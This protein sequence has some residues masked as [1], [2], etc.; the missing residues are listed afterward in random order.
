MSLRSWISN[1]DL[2]LSHKPLLLVFWGI[3]TF[4]VAIGAFALIFSYSALPPQVPL[5]FTAEKGLTGKLLL[6]VVPAL[7]IFFLIVNAAVSEFLL[8]KREDAAA[9]FPAFLS[10]LVSALLTGSL[11]RILRI[12]PIPKSPL[13]ELLYPLLLPFGGAVF[14]G[15]FITLGTLFL[16][17]RLRLFDRPHGPYPEVRSIPRLGALPLFLAFGIVALLFLP[18]DPALKGLLLGAGI[19][20]LIQTV[21]DLHSLPFWVQGLGHLIAAGAVIWGGIRVTYIGNPL[22]PYLAPRY[23][24]FSAVPYLSELV[25][26]VWIF[27]LINVVDWLDGLD[28]LAAGIGT[29]AAV[30]IVAASFVLG[31]PA[32]ALLGV[33]LAGI[34][35][36]FLPLNA[37]PAK[38]YLG[39]G[40][41]LLG[42]L[43]A[44]LSIFSGAKTGTAIL[45][46]AVP[47][48]DAF[49]VI[50]SRLRTGKSPF[51]GDQRHL[52]H[53]LME[54]GISHPKIVFLEWAI[55]TALAVAAVVLRGPSKLAA[56]GLVLLA[57]LLVNQQ[58]LRRAG[59]K[60]QTPSAPSN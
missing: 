23:L 4:L 20:T 37:Y 26:A 43:L 28:G 25:T 3:A 12:F 51:L 7:A 22:W 60:D 46:L 33:V 5:L 58:L 31:T 41:F 45:I 29:I 38:I 36:G 1:K 35:L 16:A 39:G 10:I 9:I 15:F 21:D 19:L 50:L 8:R 53:R 2:A 24:E 55:V 13:E 59:S 30:A 49:L 48:I 17:R 44:V 27:A 52:H 42:Y 54:A 14:L 34:L 40:A 56:V 11:I 47:I 18:L 57:A 6:A 32:S